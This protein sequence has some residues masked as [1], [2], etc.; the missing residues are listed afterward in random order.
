MSA[1]YGRIP[2]WGSILSRDTTGEQLSFSALSVNPRP[3]RGVTFGLANTFSK[4]IGHRAI[5]FR[6]TVQRN[7]VQ[8]R[9]RNSRPAERS[10]AGVR[11]STLGMSAGLR[12]VNN[13]HR[14][15]RGERYGGNFCI[16]FGPNV[17]QRDTTPADQES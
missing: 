1:P 14:L 8:R 4:S 15:R 5:Q 16:A 2:G 10:P 12:K 6:Q 17:D 9:P 7:H 3:A 13:L 11:K